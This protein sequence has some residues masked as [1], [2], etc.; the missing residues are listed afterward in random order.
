MDSLNVLLN[1]KS[2]L[3]RN[4]NVRIDKSTLNVINLIMFRFYVTTVVRVFRDLD[5]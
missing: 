4:V 3:R 1:V 2:R 5:S